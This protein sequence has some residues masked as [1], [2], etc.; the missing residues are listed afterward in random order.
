MLLSNSRCGCRGTTRIWGKSSANR[1]RPEIIKYTMWEHILHSC[2][3]VMKRKSC[4]NLIRPSDNLL[5]FG[6]VSYG[7][8]IERIKQRHIKQGLPFSGS[9]S[10]LP[11]YLEKIVPGYPRTVGP[12][13]R[14]PVGIKRQSN[15]KHAQLRI[16]NVTRCF[17]AP[18]QN[19][20]TYPLTVL[21]TNISE[22]PKHTSECRRT[23]SRRCT[24]SNP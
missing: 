2:S 18:K 24:P 23:R 6:S 20:K 3:K 22:F 9:V 17:A 12:K 1:F 21:P 7:T 19:D 13:P 4:R 8:G 15:G 10:R 5:S 14:S 16:Q 11:S